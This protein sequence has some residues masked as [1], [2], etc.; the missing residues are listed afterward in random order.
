M[1]KEEIKKKVCDFLIE[2]FEVDASKL[3]ND[4]RLRED[5]GLESLDFVDIVVIVKREFGFVI[6]LEEMKS[7]NTL[8]E[9]CDFI[10]NKM[11]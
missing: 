3:S 2:E 8:K 6:A 7:V 1:S 5:M 4:A 9:L 11:S 10:D